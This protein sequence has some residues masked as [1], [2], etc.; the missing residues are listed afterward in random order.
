MDYGVLPRV[1]VMANP[2]L[3][4][5]WHAAKCEALGFM[6]L[7]RMNGFRDVPAV[8]LL[9][10][11]LEKGRAL[12]DLLKGSGTEPGSVGAVDITF[13]QN[14]T[15]RAY[16]LVL[17]ANEDE[18]IDR[19]FDQERQADYAINVATMAVAKEFPLSANFIW[20]R[21]IAEQKAIY[22][23]PA[24]HAGPDIDGGLLKNDVVFRDREKLS[25]ES[26]EYFLTDPEDNK[27]ELPELR[28]APVLPAEI[29]ERRNRQLGRFF[30]ISTAR[31][32]FNST[33][34]SAARELSGEFAAWQ[35]F[36]AACNLTCAARFPRLARTD[37]PLDWIDVYEALRHE[38]EPVAS[39]LALRLEFSSTALRE[40]LIEDAR[41]L[42]TY[43]VGPDSAADPFSKLASLGVLEPR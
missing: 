7:P 10:R 16:T 13:I 12:F 8:A 43:L 36:Q 42:C 5:L 19:M 1:M 25:S 31:L 33:Y 28:H 38:P 29:A 24:S 4:E 34:Q 6:L 3:P 27:P 11:S 30:P 15:T 18:L 40:Q 39:D 23:A 32:P 22:F 35:I 21:K 2:A 20:L 14:S 37:G 26:I 17:K 9:F 41:Y